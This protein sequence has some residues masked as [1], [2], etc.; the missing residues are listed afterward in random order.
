MIR[1]AVSVEGQTEEEFVKRVLAGHLQQTCG[2]HCVQP[3]LLGRAG[4]SNTGGGDVSENRL[5]AEM[6]CLIGSFDAVTC[7]V[8]YYGFKD[9]GTST[10]DELADSVRSRVVEI[11]KKRGERILPY[12]QVH[13]FEGLLFSDVNA[14]TILEEANPKAINVLHGIRSSVGSPEKIND[15]PKTAPSKRIAK[16]IPKFRKRL[17][18]LMVAEKAGLDKIRE[19]CPRFN[20][21]VENL[22]NLHSRISP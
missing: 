14:F 3:I 8:D 20:A 19:E 5:V 10:A 6:V 2:F 13:E 21:W 12:V 7:L 11:T 17:H 1:L 4:S 22:E 16:I 18:G 15:D 9:K